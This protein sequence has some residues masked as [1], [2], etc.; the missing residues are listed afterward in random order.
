MTT[1][2]RWTLIGGTVVILAMA[3]GLAWWAMKPRYTVLFGSLRQADAA[4]IAGAL[5]A[6]QVPHRFADDG[7]SL[8]V[9]EDVVYDTRMKLVAQNV[10]HGSSVG[11]EVFKDSDFGVTEFAQQV[12]YQRA[13]QGELERTIAT[14]GEVE[15]ARVHLTLRRASMF[16]EKDAPS[17][18]SVSLALH[19]GAHLMPTQVAGIQ[20]LVASAV[21]G[22]DAET[23]VVLG[24]GGTVLAGG[25]HGAG[26]VTDDSGQMEARLRQRIDTLLKDS[27][28]ARTPYSVSVD[29]RVNYDRIK[30]IKDTLV[31]QGQDGNG[32]LLRE[33]TAGGHATTSVDAQGNKTTTPGSGDNELEFAHSREQEEVEVAPGKVER[34]SIG[35]LLPSSVDAAT[36]SKLTS[37]IGAAAGLD[38]TR[39][40]QLTVATLP[41]VA[42]VAK[43]VPSRPAS[44]RV[45]APEPDAMWW[46]LGAGSLLV[47]LIGA[48]TGTVVARTKQPKRLS[49]QSREEVLADVRKWLRAPEGL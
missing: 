44:P 43:T 48:A 35:V 7:A 41:V 26:A 36:V 14:I 6:M 10:P 47:V 32:L 20:R 4:E 33:K 31:P 8:L 30:H 38:A 3:G 2:R 40:D 19:P 34:I 45:L 15:S 25:G 5:D 21:E 29:V 37:V 17:K 16:D 28:G 13:L 9:P 39:G 23:V 27:L 42:G 1:R 46:W 22:L 24:D 11:F 18:A 49:R 12:N